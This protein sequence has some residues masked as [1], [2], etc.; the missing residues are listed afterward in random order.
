ME[1]LHAL[2]QKQAVEMVRTQKSLGFFKRLFL[3]PKPN[4]WQSYWRPVFDLS[5]LNKF[6]KTEKFK[7]ETPENIR[8][9]HG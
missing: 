2:M 6:L 5:K 8:T 4:N 7:M 1:A 3:V 9:W